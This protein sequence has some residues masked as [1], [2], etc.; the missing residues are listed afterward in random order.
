MFHQTHQIGRSC[1]LATLSLLHNW[2]QCLKP[3]VGPILVSS[4][5]TSLQKDIWEIL[6]PLFN[7]PSPSPLYFKKYIC[8]VHR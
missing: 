3:M 6:L 2:L 4:E 7:H 1:T 8:T 5:E